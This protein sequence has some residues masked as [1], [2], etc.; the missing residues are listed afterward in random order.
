MLEN[1]R[2]GR[3]MNW[4]WDD[5]D[6][7]FKIENMLGQTYKDCWVNE[8]DDQLIFA[9]DDHYIVFY[10][11]QDCCEHVVLDD[12]VGELTDLIGNPI[13]L[14]DESSNQSDYSEWGDSQ[15]WTFYKFATIKGYVDVKW[16]GTSNGY[17]S[18]RV[19]VVKV[20]KASE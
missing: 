1:V 8:H 7:S 5:I 16:H 6:R 10:H 13:T 17:Y 20:M 14:V 4:V 15:T 2:R 11:S 9:A 18:E 12:I 3:S 19:D